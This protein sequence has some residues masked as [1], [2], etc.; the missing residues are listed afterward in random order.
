MKI[1]DLENSSWRSYFALFYVLSVIVQNLDPDP[2]PITGT[3]ALY[4]YV[5]FSCFLSATDLN[6]LQLEFILA[7]WSRL[8]QENMGEATLDKTW[9]TLTITVN[10]VSS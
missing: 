2:D 1:S 10:E 5:V 3:D 6:F 7:E 9:R 4:L 8:V